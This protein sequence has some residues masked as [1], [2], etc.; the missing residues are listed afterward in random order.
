MPILLVGLNHKTAPIEVRERLA[1]S[2]E[3]CGESL[4]ALVD[5]EVVREGLIVSTCNRVEVLTATND[6]REPAGINRI[7]DFLSQSRQIPHSDFHLHLYNYTDEQAVRHLFRVAS[8]LD[9]MVVGEPQVLGQV[10]RAYSQAIEAGTAGRILSRLVHQA[11][12]VAKR[13]RNETG[14]AASAVSISYMAVELGRKIFGSLKNSTVLLI[15][16]G[17]MA[18]LSAR[19]LLNAGATRVLIANRTL[20]SAQKLAA[21]FGG[22]A[23]DY[24]N[25]AH[26]LA[27]ADIVICSTAAA[28]NEYV[29]TKKMAR[30]ASETR[31]NR[32]SFFIDISVPRNVDPAISEIGNL[33]VF[34]V[35]D[36]ESVVASNVRE[37]EREAERAELIVE[38]EVT[39]FQQTLRALDFGPEVGALRRKMQ[40]IAR[41]EITRQRTRLGELSLEQEQAIEALL[42]STVNKIS[43]PLMQLMRRSYDAGEAA[44]VQAW[45]DIF[46]LDE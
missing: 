31:R 22:Q 12:R 45:R 34:D 40:S 14:I 2:D 15:G 20:A 35:D 33:F 18:E 26:H 29:V 38:S 27:E 46:G 8:S 13:V 30:A 28:N 19:H 1:F 3:A 24:D 21:D 10:R 7:A 5:G 16:A 44:D 17:E 23:I 4:R 36:L 39:Q 42:L 11:F 37:R 41:D 9:S 43:H 25:L 6:A 32:P